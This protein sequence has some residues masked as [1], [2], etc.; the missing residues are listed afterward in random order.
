MTSIAEAEAVALDALREL[1]LNHLTAW[2]LRAVDAWAEAC[3]LDKD[4]IERAAHYS[5]DHRGFY[6][7][8]LTEGAREVRTSEFATAVIDNM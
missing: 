1:G 7:A 8:R 5:V 6:L 2:H 4:P 3:A